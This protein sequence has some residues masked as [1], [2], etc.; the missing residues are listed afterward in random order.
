M[1]LK[2]LVLAATLA[3]AGSAFAHEGA[4]GDRDVTVIRNPQDHTV[5]RIVRREHRRDFDRDRAV[6]HVVI[7][8]PHHRHH[9]VVR[10]V[11]LVH[12][13]HPG[14]TVVHRTV[15]VHRG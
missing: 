4:G 1:T 8:H 9:R 3:L 15:I 10:K 6:R 11:V 14:R 13:A 2:T 5:T 12:P 7:L